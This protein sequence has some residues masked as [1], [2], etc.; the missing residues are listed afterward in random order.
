MKSIHLYF[1]DHN[2]HAVVG[3]YK[4]KGTDQWWADSFDAASI[5]KVEN[6]EL[7]ILKCRSLPSIP[8]KY[9]KSYYGSTLVIEAKHDDPLIDIII[10]H[11]EEES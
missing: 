11:E 3:Y 4:W 8:H 2:I 1:D 9:N 7:T 10:N 5:N 6:L